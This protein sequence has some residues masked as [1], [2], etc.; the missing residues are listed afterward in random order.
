MN[1]R[2][3]EIDN[4]QILLQRIAGENES[5]WQVIISLYLDD[6]HEC[7]DW[8]FFDTIAEAKAWIVAFDDQQ[9]RLFIEKALNWWSEE[10]Q[11][12]RVDLTHK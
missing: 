6:E 10:Q 9:A 7:S 1:F 11:T 3:L 4:R 8:M 5:D 2:L 12:M